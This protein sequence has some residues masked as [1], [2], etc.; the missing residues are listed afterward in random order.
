VELIFVLS[1]EAISELC[2]QKSGDFSHSGTVE[3]LSEAGLG[4]A[5]LLAARGQAHKVSIG[6]DPLGAHATET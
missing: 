5:G 4:Y 2:I 6:D 3:F 1:P